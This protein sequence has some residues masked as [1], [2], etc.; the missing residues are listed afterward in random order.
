LIVQAD[1]VNIYAKNAAKA[2]VII[3]PT[4]LVAANG[5]AKSTTDK[6]IVPKMPVRSADIVVYTQ[7]EHVPSPQAEVTRIIVAVSVN[8]RKSIAIPKATIRITG[9]I[10]ITAVKRRNAVIM[11]IIKLDKAAKSKQS[12][13]HS[14]LNIVIY[15]PPLTDYAG[16]AGG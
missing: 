10:V 16:F 8:K 14:Q 5:I 2:P 4:M 13:L 3:A 11:P 9:V 15:S 12:L 6:R 1:V 7:V